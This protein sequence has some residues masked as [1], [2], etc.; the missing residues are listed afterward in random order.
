M[1]RLCRPSSS[2][3]P[4]ANDAGRI[5]DRSQA[6]WSTVENCH[7]SLFL[8]A[9]VGAIDGSYLSADECLETLRQ[10]PSLLRCIIRRLE[11]SNANRHSHTQVRLEHLCSLHLAVAYD[12]TT[13]ALLDRL[14]V[15]AISE[16]RLKSEQPRPTVWCR[17]SFISLLSR[18]TPTRPGL[19]SWG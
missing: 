8:E 10:T 16:I 15:P 5:R 7:I 12:D 4:G 17:A 1:C 6:T 18:S 11:F 13:S 3:R 9:S 19:Y 2:K 14:T